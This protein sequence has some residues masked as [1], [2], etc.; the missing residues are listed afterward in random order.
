MDEGRARAV[1]RR[2][3]AAGRG[4]EPLE[5]RRLL[6]AG[7]AQV[8]FREI[9][10]KG[11]TA[12]VITGTNRADFIAITDNGT[13]A[14]GNV[15][16]ALGDGRTYTSQAAITEVEVLAKG[17]DDQVSYTLA[18]D[19]TSYRAV[20][21]DLGAGNDQFSANLAGAIANSDGLDLQ[22]NGDSG[23]D[24]LTA[25]QAGATE[26][27]TAFVY[28]DGGSGNDTI[29]Y[30]GTGVVATGATLVPGLSGGSG[31][32]TIASN[33]S[34]QVNGTYTYNLAIDGGAGN[35]DLTDNIHVAAG[36]VG[37]VGSAGGTPAAV[38]G[39]PGND[40]IHFNVAVDPSATQALVNAIAVGGPGKD[41]VQRT[42]N[43]Q[44]D[45]SNESD[46]VVS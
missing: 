6:S 4:L 15:T 28:L 25:T 3:V 41:V 32:D 1:R 38:L 5:G 31:N 26:D 14:P 18:G 30:N 13:A 12:L 24:T 35:D 37:S 33:Y 42:A 17:G 22:V 44:G 7:G 34:G 11:A 9:T 21:V 45:S 29:A 40:Q 43:V 23:D 39:G 27:G 10:S 36:S 8:G 19:L 46:T 16:V 20:L 2:R